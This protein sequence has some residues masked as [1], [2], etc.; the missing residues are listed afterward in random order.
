MDGDENSAG[1]S[2]NSCLTTPVTI[3]HGDECEF[4][5][6]FPAKAAA[7]SCVYKDEDEDRMM[8]VCMREHG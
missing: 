2:S 8:S 6:V 1:I 5:A 3:I 7:D 4:S